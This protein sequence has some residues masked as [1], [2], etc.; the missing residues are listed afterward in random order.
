MIQ[1][2]LRLALG[3]LLAV[4]GLGLVHAKGRAIQPDDFLRFATVASPQVSPDG[5]WVA[6][7]VST[8]DRDRDE[9]RTALWLA[10]WDGQQQLQLTK[11]LK[12]VDSPRFSPDGR[13]IAFLATPA[14]AE[15]VQVMLLDR[16][17]GE[18]R[19]LT[20]ASDGINSIA[21]SP[22]G[23]RL[24]LVQHGG[25]ADDDGASAKPPNPSSSMRCI[26]SRTS[27]VTFRPARGSACFCWTSSRAS[28]KD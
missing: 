21:W 24:L 5:K 14:G 10:S 9:S 25:M 12:D 6:Y 19:S 23:K 11:D 8:V 18:T 3:A 4:S 22:D 16:G 20:S 2:C 13:F 17:S 15:K 7:T 28:W 1:Q 27:P 26:S